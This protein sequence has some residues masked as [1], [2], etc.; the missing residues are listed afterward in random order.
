MVPEW[1]TKVHKIMRIKE[2]LDSGQHV[3]GCFA[4]IPHPMSVEIC[5]S[6]GFDTLCID[7]EHSQFS[8]GELEELVRACDAREVAA[9]VRVP[10]VQQE[11]IAS[12]LD[13]GADAVLVPRVST[14]D[15]ARAVVD[16]ALYPPKGSRGLG[17]ARASNYGYDLSGH[18]ASASGVLVAIQIETLGGLNDVDTIA[19]VHGIDMLFVGPFDL[20]MSLRAHGHISK[21]ALPDAIEAIGRSALQH[22][23]AAGILCVNPADVGKWSSAGYRFFLTGSDAM[24]LRA[25]A[26]ESLKSSRSVVASLKSHGSGL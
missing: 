18:L 12:A 16:A 20:D 9:M 25:G 6:Q 26:A 22:G 4:A 10:G 17:A 23:K 7:A 8:R 11:W 1:R 15:A 3:F 14:P 2:Q 5:A 21:N 19:A 13:T 24:F